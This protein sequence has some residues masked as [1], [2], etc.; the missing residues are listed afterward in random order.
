MD[1]DTPPPDDNRR[2]R[3]PRQERDDSDDEPPERE[4]SKRRSREDDEDDEDWEA[5]RPRQLRRR[6]RDDDEDEDYDPG[7]RMVAP[8][9]T[10][11]LAIAA[12][13]LGLISVLCVPAPFALLLGILALR[14][15]KKHPKLDGKARAIF[16]IVMGTIFSGV[17]LV[18]GVAALVG[19]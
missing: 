16:A 9:N 19:K 8:V 4:R 3:R 18:V 17:M 7:L 11:G 10:S 12:G 2:R 1:D 15:L 13:Y 6:R 5:D 14:Y